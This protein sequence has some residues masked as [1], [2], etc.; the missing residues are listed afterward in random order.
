LSGVVRS[1]L[2]PGLSPVLSVPVS[3][4]GVAE[5]TLKGPDPGS[6]GPRTTRL[7]LAQLSWTLRQDTSISSFRLT[8]AGHQIADSAGAQSFR[9]N[10]QGALAHDPAVSLASSLFYALR[11]GR[12]VSGRIDRPTPVD[13][14]FGKHPYGIGPFAVSLDGNQ[15]AGVTPSRLLLGPTNAGKGSAPA[16]E[17]MSGAGLLRPSW[18]FARRLWEVQNLPTGAV[19]GYVRG[20]RFHAVRFPGISREDVRRFL[21][22]RDGSRLVAVVRGSSTDRIVVSRVRYD[23]RGHPLSGTRARLIPWISGGTTRIRDI[24]WSTPATIAVLDQLSR[25][26]AEARILDVDG[27]TAADETPS[28]TIPGRALGLVTSPVGGTTPYAVTA[29]GLFDLAQVDQRLPAT[30]TV[31]TGRLRHIAYAG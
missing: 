25:R 26:Q 20:D 17:V 1:F 12:L 9:V 5:V 7:I 2:P 22:S 8:I 27:S 28:T 18:D 14:P 19:V 3:E 11:A 30:A 24:G 23:D 16:T 29:H 10:T 6:L 4:S 21:V 13:G 31:Q 15:V